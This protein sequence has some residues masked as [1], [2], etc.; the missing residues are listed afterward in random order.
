MGPDPP[1][2]FCFAATWAA[3]DYCYM[4]PVVGKL[5]ACG[6]CILQGEERRFNPIGELPEYTLK[7]RWKWRMEMMDMFFGFLGGGV[8]LKISLFS[9]EQLKLSIEEATKDSRLAAG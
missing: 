5:L 3:E 8:S 9:D 6:D 2:V 7:V 1:Y 4:V